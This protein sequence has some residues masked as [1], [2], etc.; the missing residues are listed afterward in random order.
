MDD[1]PSEIYFLIMDQLNYP[2]RTALERVK[3]IFRIL[4]VNFFPK[5]KYTIELGMMYQNY[6]YW[7]QGQKKTT[8]TLYKSILREDSG[9]KEWYNYT[10]QQKSSFNFNFD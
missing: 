7:I 4:N 9:F 10:N 8:K 2:Q 3:K 1:L 6:Y 5:F